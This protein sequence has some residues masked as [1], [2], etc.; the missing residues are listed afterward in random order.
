MDPGLEVKTLIQNLFGLLCVGKSKILSK[1]PMKSFFVYKYFTGS[2][3]S[4]NFSLATNYSS[5]RTLSA[6][7]KRQGKIPNL[8]KNQDRCEVLAKSLGGNRGG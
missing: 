3:W 7:G 5:F 6:K 1:K 4:S 2:Y 8:R